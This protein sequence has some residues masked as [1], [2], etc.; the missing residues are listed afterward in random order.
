M[1]IYTIFELIQTKPKIYEWNI[2][3]VL[4]IINSRTFKKAYV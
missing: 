2:S 3:A 1:Y 4:N